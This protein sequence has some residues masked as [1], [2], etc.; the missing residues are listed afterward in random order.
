MI[1]V[2]DDIYFMWIGTGPRRHAK[3]FDV[4]NGEDIF[5]IKEVFAGY[6][7]TNFCTVSVLS[8]CIVFLEWFV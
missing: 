2:K 1:Y 4:V 6:G 5:G 7:G 3:L 8:H